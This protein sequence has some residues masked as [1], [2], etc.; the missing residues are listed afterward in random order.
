MN[1]K[2]SILVIALTLCI[3]L[4]DLNAQQ[5]M[6]KKGDMVL[7]ASVGF[8]SVLFSGL[9]YTTSVPPVAASVEYGLLDKVI[10]KGSI[11]VGGYLGYSA[12]KWEYVGW[13]WK[14]NNII[15]GARGALHY[16]FVAKLDTYTGLLV[17]LNLRNAKAFG[18]TNP[19]YG[20]EPTGNG[21]AWSWFLGARYYFNKQLAA[22]AEIGYGIAWLNIGIAFSLN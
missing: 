8:G 9:G 18:P 12:Y 10:D 5:S 17:G 4:V 6:F 16:P 19:L 11:G 15:F 2:K 21:P 3:C 14:Y 7:N 20:Y 22:L 1:M 13:G